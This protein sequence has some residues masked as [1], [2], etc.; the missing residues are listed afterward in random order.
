MDIVETII[1]GAGQAGL[2]ASYFLTQQNH[3]HI[4]LDRAPKVASAWRDGRWDSFTLVT[5]NW[6]LQL[7]GAEYGGRDPDGFLTPQQIIEYLETYAG[8]FR[9]PIQTGVRVS[10]VTPIEISAGY[11]VKTNRG[12]YKARNVIVAT[13]LY[14]KP[15]IPSFG[16][17][18]PKSIRQLHSSKYRSPSQLPDGGILIVGS[19]QSGAQIAEELYQAGRKVF[20][21][22]GRNVR[23][24]R[25]YRGKDIHRWSQLLGMFDRTVDQ[26]GSPAEKFDPHPTISG[27]GGGRTLNLHQFARDRVVLLGRLQGVAGGRLNLAPDLRENLVKSDAFE[28]ATVQRIDE[29]VHKSRLDAPEEILPDFRDGFNAPMVVSLDLERT[30]IT[31]V[32]WASGYEFDFSWVRLPV[33]DEVGYPIQ[34]RGVTKFP[35]LYFLGM[36]WLYTR[37]SGILYGAGEDARY[38]TSHILKNSAEACPVSEARVRGLL[39]DAAMTAARA[40][41]SVGE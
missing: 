4:V 23:V 33:L 40:F 29:Y 34:K 5:P 24:P 31:S 1:I 28:K 15:R 7:P 20:L 13:G 2:A 12:N 30:G 36:P 19:S 22:V 14:Q 11:I 9:L 32:I 39:P 10:G 16:R 25:R 8:R 6:Q 38:L 17:D 18:F 41:G 21:S 37:K 35:G 3:S 26:L 27:K